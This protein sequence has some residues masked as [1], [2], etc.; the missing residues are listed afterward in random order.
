MRNPR[1]Y[2]DASTGAAGRCCGRSTL[3]P[4]LKNCWVA[5]V[6]RSVLLTYTTLEGVVV[7]VVHSDVA[8][9]EDEVIYG[10]RQCSLHERHFLHMYLQ[11]D[12]T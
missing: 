11:M 5:L 4:G 12:H 9:L 10:E 2:T 8:W 3:Y 7:V 1:A 6:A